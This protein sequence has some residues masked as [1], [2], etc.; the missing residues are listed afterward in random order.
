MHCKKSQE[1]SFHGEITRDGRTGGWKTK[2]ERRKHLEMLKVNKNN[3]KWIVFFLVAALTYLSLDILDAACVLRQIL[4]LPVSLL[5]L[6]VDHYTGDYA[7][8]QFLDID[9]PGITAV[10]FRV[11][12]F[13]IILGTVLLPMC[14]YVRTKKK[15]YFVLSGIA[16]ALIIGSFCF[17]FFMAWAMTG[18]MD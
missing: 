3:W 6:P 15:T 2:I 7:L 14:L 16:I 1:K 10:C 9:F 5:I 8:G 18:T 17:F 11:C 12:A 4:I 13:A